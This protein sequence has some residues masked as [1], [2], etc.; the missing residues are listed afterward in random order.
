MDLVSLG[1][2]AGIYGAF[3]TYSARGLVLARVSLSQRDSYRLLSEAGELDAESSGALWYRAESAAAMPVVG[4]WV[5]ARIAAPE[6]AIVEAVL[7][8]RT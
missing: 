1:A 3:Q 7:P 6:Y 8:R 2:D 4:D 5:A